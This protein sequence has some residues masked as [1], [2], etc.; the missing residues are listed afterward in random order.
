[1]YNNVYI[2]SDFLS[3]DTRIHRVIHYSEKN[4]NAYQIQ[5]S[6]WHKNCYNITILVEF[7]PLGAFQ[8]HG[9]DI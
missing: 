8:S 1:M 5:K 9:T 4:Y 6:T 2:K 3:A 7:G